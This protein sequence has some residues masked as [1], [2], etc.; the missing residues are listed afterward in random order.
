MRTRWP[1]SHPETCFAGC[2]T[3]WAVC[4]GVP[5]YCRC[6]ASPSLLPQPLLTTRP[7][8]ALDIGYPQQP[9]EAALLELLPSP[10]QQAAAGTSNRPSLASMLQH[11]EK[12]RQQSE[13]DG[14]QEAG[15]GAAA[16]A[17]SAG[18]PGDGAAAQQAGGVPRLAAADLA[19]ELQFTLQQAE[20]KALR[21][22]RA[23]EE[24]EEEKR[25]QQQQAAGWQHRG[26]SRGGSAAAG[27]AS[28]G[29]ESSGA[30]DSSSA[31]QD[32][33][34]ALLQQGIQRRPL[35]LGKGKVPLP[36]GGDSTGTGTA[37][38][39]PVGSGVRMLVGLISACCTEKAAERRAIV[40]DTWARIIREVGGDGLRKCTA[41]QMQ[42]CAWV[43]DWLRPASAC[44]ASAACSPA[45]VCLLSGVTFVH[46]SSPLC[47]LQSHPGIDL[48]FF[49]AQPPDAET[50]QRWLPALQVLCGWRILLLHSLLSRTLLLITLS[51]RPDAV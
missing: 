24:R 51:I 19:N 1:G 15:G 47:N 9:A 21:E 44:P 45:L 12:K 18:G 43:A 35:A 37:A 4:V 31:Y 22:K 48:R 30:D 28:G 34:Q 16:G 39:A 7:R 25:Q 41:W 20:E 17:G 36:A 6:H 49:L 42:V 2:A 50:A 46:A 26:S 13:A 29:D 8:Q 27:Q 3:G 32:L 33:S 5:A 23:A 11:Y 10:E 14:T 38:A 40:R